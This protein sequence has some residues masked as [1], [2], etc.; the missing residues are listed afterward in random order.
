MKPFQHQEAVARL[1]QEHDKGIFDIACG[2]GKSYS[3]MLASKHF[4]VT[5]VFA[6]TKNLVSQLAE[7]FSSMSD[8]KVF[9]VNS[10]NPVNMTQLRKAKMAKKKRI[11]IV[12]NYQSVHVVKDICETT[13][14]Q[15][16]AVFLDE[17]HNVTSDKK[18]SV[19]HKESNIEELSDNE[20][21]SG[22]EIDSDTEDV[23]DTVSII[24][25]SSY[26][27]TS[28]GS[29]TDSNERFVMSDIS[30]ITAKKTF[31][32]TATPTKV[33]LKH[34]EIYGPVLLQYSYAQGVIDGHV[35]NID[36]IIECYG[37]K[38]KSCLDAGYERLIP[39]ISRFI[40][41]GNFKRII[42]YTSRVKE[43]GKKLATVD[44]LYDNRQLFPDEFHIHT[45]SANT[46][47]GVRDDIFN[48]FRAISDETHVILSCMTI[49][50]GIDLPS[51]DS[52]VILDSSKSVVKIVQRTLRACRL[53]Q[54]ERTCG[55][56]RNAAVFY[57]INVPETSFIEL[58]N[59]GKDEA[60][61]VL[62]KHVHRHEFEFAMAVVHFI[63]QDLGLEPLFDYTCTKTTKTG[64][65]KHPRMQSRKSEARSSPTTLKTQVTFNFRD[66]FEWIP[67][68]F[69]SSVDYIITNLSL[70]DSDER[71]KS[72]LEKV[73]QFV[74]ANNKLPS[75]TSKDINEAYIGNWCNR[76]RFL[77]KK[78]RLTSERTTEIEKVT[79]WSWNPSDDK[80][81]ERFAKLKEFLNNNENRYPSIVSQV[82]SEQSL[83]RWV[84]TCKR[85]YDENKLSDTQKEDFLSLPSWSWESLRD[86]KF[87]ECFTGVIK[88]ATEHQRLP[89]HNSSESNELK[90]ARWCNTRR[91]EY[92]HG[93]LSDERIRLIQS[94][95]RWE[96]DPIEKSFR[97]QLDNYKRFVEEYCR[98]P[99]STSSNPD[100]KKI[101]VWVRKIRQIK[102]K[103]STDK[104]KEFNKID[105]FSWNPHKDKFEEYV[106]ELQ[107]FVSNH[108]RLPVTT[109]KN[110]NEEKLARW[111]EKQRGLKRKGK[112]SE[113]KCKQLESVHF[114]KWDIFDKNFT[115]SLEAVRNFQI[116]HGRIPKQY[117]TD[118]QE[119]SLGG[120]CSRQRSN[121][122]NGKLSL[123]NIL[124]LDAIQG[125]FWDVKDNH[126]MTTTLQ[127]P[128]I[129][130]SSNPKKRKRELSEL[131]EYHKRFK[132]LSS[133]NLH[134]EF[135]EDRELFNDY[136]EVAEKNWNGFK[137]EDRPVHMASRLVDKIHKQV[138]RSLTITDFG[139]GVGTLKELINQE[140]I[141][142]GFDHISVKDW[143]IPRDMRDTG[144]ESA[145]QDV[146][147]FSMSLWGSNWEEY[148]VEA[149][150]V[151][152]PNGYC[153]IINKTRGWFV[154]EENHPLP[155]KETRIGK[156]LINA[157]L[158]TVKVSGL[159]S[160]F[161][162]CIAMKPL[163]L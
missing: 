66:M 78:E 125:W 70:S 108:E 88:F 22:S 149:S 57:P 55:E 17:A 77:R 68:Q 114:W 37:D 50:E 81:K 139:A 157:G 156:A 61:E 97:I 147:V 12:A 121:K 128:T 48:T 28:S 21:M 40:T 137:P 16:D 71:F 141:L 95:P 148:L 15:I 133:K 82:P 126:K 89:S 94:I 110:L 123:E 93:N 124:K 60:K 46:P 38:D 67:E 19:F 56:W 20:S 154:D 42:V 105:G 145:S 162:T 64:S 72:N 117:S 103:L 49:S 127:K 106:L 7:N 3:M 86:L 152:K 85:F 151:L 14:L 83:A 144:L 102:D 122:K 131:S 1:V 96:W 87:Q 76:Q 26:T 99:S 47:L 79:K 98:Q 159:E 135:Q 129:S 51:C 160:I 45:V 90:L 130:T 136:H 54:Q 73:H 112:L 119:K 74:K 161:T 153:I 32:F 59:T 69:Q 84:I 11:V 25:G 27:E 44:G 107:R 158:V 30:R 140:H 13:D 58:L 115:E 118:P 155:E 100:E 8:V 109:S 65:K 10:D 4:F 113:D 29:T 146:C 101:G 134:K 75:T 62:T 34:P 39:A 138:N 163:A 92:K 23:S 132:T 53:T 24:S 142:T 18:R 33:M 63:K 5:V 104:I 150:R 43:C 31:S 41:E 35:K 2:C 111:C 116:T 9:L 91:Q 52:V 6:P 143:I 120:W 36:T 80:Y